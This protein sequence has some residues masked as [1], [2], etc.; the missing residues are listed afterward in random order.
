MRA[1]AVKAADLLWNGGLLLEQ[2]PSGAGRLNDPGWKAWLVLGTQRGLPLGSRQ[3][4]HNTRHLQRVET[5]ARFR[6]C[7][8][9]T[10]TVH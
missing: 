5:Q 2:Q 3:V 10:L 9:R 4:L 6:L 8:D 1:L 7:T